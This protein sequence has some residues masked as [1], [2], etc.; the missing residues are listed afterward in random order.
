MS[1]QQK[2][3]QCLWKRAVSHRRSV[4]AIG[5]DRSSVLSREGYKKGL[6]PLAPLNSCFHALLGPLGTDGSMSSFPRSHASYPAPVPTL[7][8]KRTRAFHAIV[9][10]RLITGH[11]AECRGGGRARPGNP[12]PCPSSKPGERLAPLEAVGVIFAQMSLGS[13]PSSTSHYAIWGKS[14]SL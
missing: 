11:G 3:G 6:P 8:I 10:D 9:Q 14:S 4:M 2:V 12:H 13:N 7:L 5:S 1:T